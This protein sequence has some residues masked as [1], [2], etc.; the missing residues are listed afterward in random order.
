[1]Y[2]I[3]KDKRSMQSA[4]LIF[5]GLVECIKN[6]P[7]ELITITDLQKTSHVARTTF[8]RSFD[9]LSDILFWKC[10]SC[11]SEVL[12][13]YDP[14]IFKG[15]LEL[16]HHYFSYWFTH[17]EI[18]ELLI[19]INRQDIIYSCHMKNADLLQQRFGKIPGVDPNYFM[20]IRTGFT[21]SVLTAWLKGGRKET[22]DEVVKIIRG[23]LLLL[24][25][26]AKV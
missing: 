17:S 15:E 7:F 4:E 23:Q 24:A 18:L 14:S 5:N 6:K 13:S 2:H 19:K 3:S 21:I 22:P 11:F 9:N 1:M 25:K 12:G 8:Y 16:V 20:A 10:D 26:E